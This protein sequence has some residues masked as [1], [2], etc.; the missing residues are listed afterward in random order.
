MIHI[1]MKMMIHIKNVMINVLHVKN[2]EVQQI[3]IV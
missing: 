2:Q 1:M 3:I